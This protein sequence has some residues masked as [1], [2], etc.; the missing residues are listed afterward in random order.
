MTIDLE[1][2]HHFASMGTFFLTAVTVVIMVLPLVSPLLQ[3]PPKADVSTPQTKGPQQQQPQKEPPRPF[4]AQVPAQWALPSLLAFSL[5]AAGF[6]HLK[7]ARI[8]RIRGTQA[9]ANDIN[10]LANAPIQPSEYQVVK[11][12]R[13]RVIDHLSLTEEDRRKPPVWVPDMD[14][15]SGREFVVTSVSPNGWLTLADIPWGFRRDWVTP[16]SQQRTQE[17]CA[18]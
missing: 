15:Y 1:R 2:A 17:E 8:E 13:V 9:S 14:Q 11:G 4:W 16:S 12:A 7:A 3:P 18:G 5:I 6:L 10:E